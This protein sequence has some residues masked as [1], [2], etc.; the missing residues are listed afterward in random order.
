MAVSYVVYGEVREGLRT[1]SHQKSKSKNKSSPCA[2]AEHHAM[3][4]YSG[5]EV[6]PHT[7]A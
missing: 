6:Y 5:V 1:V 3:K 4:A 2:L 7:F